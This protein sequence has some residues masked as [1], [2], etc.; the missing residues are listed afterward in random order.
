MS[1][2]FSL[3][4]QLHRILS[5]NTSPRMLRVLVLTSL[6]RKPMPSQSLTWSI[7]QFLMWRHSATKTGE[8]PDFFTMEATKTAELMALS[9]T[10]FRMQEFHSRGCTCLTPS[11]QWK[12]VARHSCLPPMKETLENMT[13]LKKS[14]PSQTYLVIILS[15]AFGTLLT[16]P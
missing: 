3:V 12:K 15:P 13:V 4:Q 16:M 6:C 5:P 7:K 10:Q 14:Q 1:A 8:P 9:P 11:P 2:C